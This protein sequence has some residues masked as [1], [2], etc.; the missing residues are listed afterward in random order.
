MEPISLFLGSIAGLVIEFIKAKW[1]TGTKENILAVLVFS[2]VCGTALWTIQHFG[3]LGTVLDI[4]GTCGMVYAFI[5]KPT[6]DAN[7]ARA[8][9]ANGTPQ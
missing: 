2:L 3:F 7:L 1:Q 9:K 8:Q 6:E 4:I 5:I